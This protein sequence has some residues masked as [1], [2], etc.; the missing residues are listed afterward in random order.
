MA[1]VHLVERMGAKLAGMAFLME[2][3]FLNPRE[4]IAKATDAEVFSLIKVK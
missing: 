1:Q 4:L 2:L 3:E